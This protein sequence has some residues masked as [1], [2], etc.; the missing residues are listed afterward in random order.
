M[1][2]VFFDELELPY[3]D[4]YLGVGS[5]THAEQT[6]KELAQ[7]IAKLKAVKRGLLHDLLTRGIDANGELRPPQAEAPYLYTK[8]PLGWIPKDC[9]TQPW[10]ERNLCASSAKYRRTSW[11]S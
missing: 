9:I 1:S 6:A 8:S 5:G 11:R 2:K 10:S 3:P 4:T 7:V